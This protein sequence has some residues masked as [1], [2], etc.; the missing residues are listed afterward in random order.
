MLTKPVPSISAV[1]AAYQAEEWIA[2]TLESILGQTRPPDEVVVV[3][4]GSTD[5][6]ARELER[7]AVE[8]RIV[9]QTNCGYAQAFNRSFSKARDDY[10]ANCDADDIWEPDKLERQ[11][12]ALLTQPEI[13]IAVSG[14]RFFGLTEGPRVTYPCAGLLERR[15]LARRL[16]RA[17]FVCSSSIL[18]RRRLYEQLGPF[19]DSAAPAEDYDYWLRALAA[20]AVFF[21]DPSVLVRYRAY[22]QQV[23]SNLL[24]MLDR[25]YSVHGWHSDLVED[26]RLV[27][28]VQARDL[29]NIA[30]VLSDNNRSR[31]ARSV[32]VSSLRRRPTLRTLA[33]VLVLSAPDR[34]G[35]PLADR[36]VSIKRKLY[37]VV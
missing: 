17:N 2:E 31:E 33:W 14:V 28:K 34:Y 20:G 6:T 15:E 5:G 1:V 11:V 30:R 3:D 13:D 26:S 16:Y 22:A 8:V 12:E 24:R 36:L 7:F 18:I 25:T 23:S 29:A 35:R 10:I 32:F 19:R 37:S 4:D 9:R 21:Y 27:R